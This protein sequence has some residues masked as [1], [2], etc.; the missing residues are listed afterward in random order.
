MTAG[1]L[2]HGDQ[3]RHA[4]TFDIFATYEVPRTFGGNHDDINIFG[5]DNLFKVNT[6]AVGCA[7]GFAGFEVR[8]DITGVDF[9]L[10]F[11]RQRGNNQISGF[12]CFRNGHWIKTM[13]NGQFTIGGVAAIGHDNLHTAV[14]QVLGMGMALRAIPQYRHSFSGQ[15]GNGS[16]ILIINFQCGLVS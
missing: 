3:T 9:G 11:I 6:E 8:P 13:L 2:M 10:Q 7:E 14:A 15:S 5:R 12:D 16:F 4:T 1:I